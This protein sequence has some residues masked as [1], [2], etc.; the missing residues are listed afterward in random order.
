MYL[1]N[2]NT[3]DTFYSIVKANRHK[4]STGIVHSF[5]GTKEELQRIVELDLYIGING[6]SLKTQE[7]LDT[8]HH[9]PIERIMLE[10]DSP[11]CEIRQSHAS[12][13]LV[14]TK[15]QAKNKITPGFLLKGRN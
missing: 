2:R 13:S 3:G 11:Y 8:L 12:S 15:F 14:T 1:H 7:N 10:T 6:C 4:F 5:T 9:I